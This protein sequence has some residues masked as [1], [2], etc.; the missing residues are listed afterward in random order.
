MDA[1]SNGSPQSQGV[2]IIRHQPVAIKSFEGEAVDSP[3][4]MMDRARG[5]L[6][7]DANQE[8][9]G[10]AHGG[11]G[12]LAQHTSYYDGFA[13]I[14][15]LP[16]VTAVAI[17]PAAAKRHR[18]FF[19]ENL[20]RWS[21]DARGASRFEDRVGMQEWTALLEEILNDFLPADMF[22]EVAVVSAVPPGC[23]EGFC[24]S[25][26]AAALKALCHFEKQHI[27]EDATSRL[28]HAI[29]RALNIEFSKAFLLVALESAGRKLGII[30]TATEEL[31]AF[32]APKPEVLS[33]SL[34]EAETR[35]PRSFEVYQDCGRQ[36]GEALALL[37]AGEFAEYTSF[38]D[39]Q[40]V[41]LP[42]V[43]SS[44]PIQYRPIVRHLVNE[45]K[46]VQAMIGAIRNEDWQM[47]GGLLF[48]SHASLSNEWRGTSEAVDLVVAEAE[49]MSSDGIYGA[50]M[51]GRGGYVLVVGLP[52]AM[53][54]FVQALK[55]QLKERFNRDPQTLIL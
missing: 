40:H 39:V 22:M 14:L 15:S 47:L 34:I 25:L 7:R 54:R 42:R 18:V 11:V 12:L 53:T 52:L 8:G 19:D 29:R 51:T 35:A 21:E 23:M 2:K 27:P 38:R 45:N 10:A 36:G 4:A 43:L 46:R 5:L 30:D 13:V 16:Q 41:D 1:S 3:E 55:S 49:Y 9:A 32:D 28:Y 48:I 6:S 33:W 20:M 31:I 24:A 50:C 44:L 26:A 17:H 37:Q